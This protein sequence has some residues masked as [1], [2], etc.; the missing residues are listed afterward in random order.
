[1]EH[2]LHFAAELVAFLL[3]IFLIY[4][5][6]WP[7]V[8]KAA[9]ERQDAVERQVQESEEAVRKLEEAQRRFDDAVAEASLEAAKIRDD[10]RA[11]AERIREE[12]R[13]QAEREVERI[14]QRGEEQLVAQRDQVMRE[15]RSEI[16]GLSF[17][18]ARKKV[19][20]SLSDDTRRGQTVDT[21]LGELDGMS[22]QKS[23]SRVE[24]ARGGV[25]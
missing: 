12:L 18:T 14:K 3:V 9:E 25:N 11:D 16:A 23:E 19:L 8:R 13:E 4:R 20:E 5:Y 17:E 2:L 15:L 10:A 22:G 7:M 1:M 6:V 24:A 21:F